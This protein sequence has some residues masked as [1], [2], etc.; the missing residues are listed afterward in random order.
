MKRETDHKLFTYT[1]NWMHNALHTA[2]TVWIWILG[3]IMILWVST[4]SVEYMYIGKYRKGLAFCRKTSDSRIIYLND[5]SSKLVWICNVFC[6]RVIATHVLFRYYNN[7]IWIWC[8]RQTRSVNNWNWIDCKLYFYFCV[9]RFDL[10]KELK[11]CWGS[12][13]GFFSSV[14]SSWSQKETRRKTGFW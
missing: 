12:M 13:S 6:S 4:V 5:I 2:I 9:G 3:C 7:W 14:P 1:R 10:Q 11:R 8:G